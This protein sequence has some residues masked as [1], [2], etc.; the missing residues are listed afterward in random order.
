VRP[1]SLRSWWSRHV[2]EHARR[3]RASL[4]DGTRVRLVCG[5]ACRFRDHS[6]I[7]L[8]SW[9]PRRTGCI[10]DPDDYKLTRESDG[11]TTFAAR[12]AIEPVG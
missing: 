6:G 8:T 11:E 3:E 5:E 7:W 10:D 12:D 4:P 1:V 2:G 9:T